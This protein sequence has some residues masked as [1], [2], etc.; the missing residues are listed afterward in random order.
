[1]APK[2]MNIACVAELK[3]KKLP[4]IPVGADH[5]LRT[6]SERITAERI[7]GGRARTAPSAASVMCAMARTC[8]GTRALEKP[9]I[10]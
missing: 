6:M 4:H 10:N 8:A 2:P 1:M 9:G 3:Q 7:L 5:D